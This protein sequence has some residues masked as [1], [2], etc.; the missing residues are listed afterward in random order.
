MSKNRRGEAPALGYGQEWHLPGVPWGSAMTPHCVS[1]EGGGSEHPKEENREQK[2]KRHSHEVSADVNERIVPGASAW[3]L[4]HSAESPGT[5]QSI[6]MEPRVF[7]CLAKRTSNIGKTGSLEPQPHPCSLASQSWWA[8]PVLI[9]GD[10]Q[11][12]PWRVTSAGT[13]A[14]STSGEITLASAS[15]CVLDP[16]ASGAARWKQYQT[17]C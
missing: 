8:I 12:E 14:S 11:M 9:P 6:A 10:T 13:V 15:P 4:Q 3:V 1:L 16:S 5:R 17:L 2:S 7:P